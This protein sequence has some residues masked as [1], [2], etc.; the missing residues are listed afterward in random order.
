MKNRQ[1]IASIIFAAFL[2]MVVAAQFSAVGVTAGKQV[3]DAGLVWK[4]EVLTHTFSVPNDS[5]EEIIIRNVRPSC[6]CV[7]VPS[8]PKKIPARG[9]T[10]IQVSVD[11]K[12]F[13]GKFRY[14]AFIQAEQ[15]RNL[16]IPLIFVGEVRSAFEVNPKRVVISK[17]TWGISEAPQEIRIRGKTDESIRVTG[18]ESKTP[19]VRAKI[20]RGPSETSDDYVIS[21]EFARN[22]PVGPLQSTVE[23]L[24]DSLL[25]PVLTIPVMLNVKGAIQVR[26][27][28]ISLG[29]LTSDAKVQELAEV[30]R[31]K[32]VGHAAFRVLKVSTEP[33]GLFVTE[34][35]VKEEG[36]LY[37]VVVRPASIPAVGPIRGALVVETDN[38]GQPVIK[39]PIRGSVL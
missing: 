13:D 39:V 32:N 19:F 29:Q 11:T 15:P 6:D 8:F 4:G 34:L 36:Q 26:P 25:Q 12:A 3:H 24:T 10:E 16:M 17:A 7:S 20:E 14:S 22:C 30:V 9:A 31:L 2:G 38:E 35:S 37:E 27:L 1:Y 18:V 28:A 5:D 23:V 33:E 21:V